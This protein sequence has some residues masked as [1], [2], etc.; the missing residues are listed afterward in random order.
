MKTLKLV[1]F[2]FGFG[3]SQFGF[4]KPIRA[5]TLESC[6]VCI[7]NDNL[8]ARFEK[9]TYKIQKDQDRGMDMIEA[10]KSQIVES[11]VV[12]R[13]EA[14]KNDE[15]T[16][17]VFNS[18]IQLIAAASP[19]DFEAQGAQMLTGILKRHPDLQKNFDQ[20]MTAPALSCQQG[21][22]KSMVS[23][24]SCFARQTASPKKNEAKNC[25]R[26]FNFEK[27]ISK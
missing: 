11:A 25:V 27:C 26:V 21:L 17:I 5:T 15:L 16:N 12:L 19:Y 23:E 9:L 8:K 10:V 22:L 4:A 1:V 3:L 13:R 6:G 18:L 14:G 20:Q 7:A 2:T 24:I